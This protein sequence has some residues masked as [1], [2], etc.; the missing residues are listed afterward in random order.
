MPPSKKLAKE[1]HSTNIT[2]APTRPVF[3]G[4]RGGCNLELSQVLLM[5]GSIKN[6][7]QDKSRDYVI[8]LF[9][10]GPV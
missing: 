10:E 4:C 2:V 9:D 1:I 6:N 5:N 7:C 8:R 3:Y